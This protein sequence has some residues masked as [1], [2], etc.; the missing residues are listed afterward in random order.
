MQGRQYLIGVIDANWS[1]EARDITF[2]ATLTEGEYVGDG[3][4]NTPNVAVIGSNT[5]NV[6]A[7]DNSYFVYTATANGTLTLTSDN[8]L[9][10]WA[11]ATEFG[12]WEFVD[13]TVTIALEIDQKAY[14][15]VATDDFSAAEIVFNASFK[16]D[17]VNAG[18]EDEV[19]TDGSAANAVVIEDNTYVTLSFWGM[20]QYQIAWDNADAN[21]V[22]VDFWSGNTVLANGDV[23]TGGNWGTDLMVYLNGYAAG[24]VNVT[25]TP[26]VEESISAE[27]ALG[28]NTITVQDTSMGDTY[29]LPVNADETVTYVLT[30]GANAVIIVNGSDIYLNVGDTVE[31]TVP[32]GETVSVGIGAYL[33]ADP[34]AIVIVAVKEETAAPEEGDGPV[35]SDPVA[36]ITI[37]AP[38]NFKASGWNEFYTVE[39]SGNYV[40]TAENYDGIQK[41]YI[42]IKVN[43]GDSITVAKGAELENQ[44]P[45][46]IALNAGD[47]VTIQLYGW[48]DADKG[49]EV[50]VILTPAA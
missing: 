37:A 34:T 9:C 29:N 49:T 8:D 50:T 19:I 20:G 23:F 3:S 28:E 16:A 45:Y 1:T 22:L 43:G 15:A 33:A 7:F 40:I 41:T 42:Q 2:T 11:V 27:L 6:P 24:T 18:Y 32:A 31:I 25:I 47:V 44:M 21:V 13:G 14:I 46:T 48:N 10:S 4:M 35:S 12:N 38:G 36:S 17:P 26:Y 5:A 30:V 39:A